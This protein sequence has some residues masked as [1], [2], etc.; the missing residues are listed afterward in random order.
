MREE[1]AVIMNSNDRFYV[2]AAAGMPWSSH[3]FTEVH[4]AIP[5]AAAARKRHAVGTVAESVRG[6]H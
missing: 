3:A 2:V 4:T 1:D 5:A 6:F